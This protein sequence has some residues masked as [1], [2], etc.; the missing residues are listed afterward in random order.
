VAD[1]LIDLP[2]GIELRPSE[3]A[4]R[5]FL[6]TVYAG[7]RSEELAVVPWTDADKAAFIKNQFDAQDAYYRQTYADAQFLVILADG[8]RVGRLYL[9]RIDDELRVIDIALLPDQRGRGIGSAL[10]AWIATL[11]DREGRSVTLHVEPWN[12]ARRLYER[13]G[14]VSEGVSGIYEFMRRPV[15]AQPQLNTAS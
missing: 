2:A 15:A 12:P 10:M 7:T 1:G 8:A 11:A 4:D 6:L 14:F 5:D 3:P 13:L 9:G